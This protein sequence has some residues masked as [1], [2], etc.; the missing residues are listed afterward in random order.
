MSSRNGILLL[1]TSALLIGCATTTTTKTVNLDQERAA[2]RAAYLAADEAAHGPPPTNVDKL[3]GFYAN[4]ASVYP[5]GG[6]I[7]VGMDALKALFAGM[8]FTKVRVTALNAQVAAAGDVGYTTGAFEVQAN[9]QPQ[10]GKYVTVWKKTDG[11][12]KIAEDIFNSDTG[13]QALE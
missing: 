5:P 7:V 2:L 4:D 10:K 12:W 3:L 8:T 6:P 1:V 11:S 13:P 9:G